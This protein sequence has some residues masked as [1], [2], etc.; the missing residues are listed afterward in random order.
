MATNIKIDISEWLKPDPDSKAHINESEI[1]N[2]HSQS[3]T[4][5]GG[6]LNSSGGILLTDKWTKLHRKLNNDPITSGYDD[7]IELSNH[8]N[9]RSNAHRVRIQAPG[10]MHN[11]LNQTSA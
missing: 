5:N 10:N 6:N 2:L 4:S 3:L 8:S 9:Y 1:L 11:C 7:E